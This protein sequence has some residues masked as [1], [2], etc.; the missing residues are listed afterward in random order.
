M[1]RICFLQLALLALVSGTAHRPQASVL[2]AMSLA[3]LAGAAESIV[4][5]SVRSVR[6]AWDDRHRTIL[7]TIEVD[8]NEV[9]KGS[10]SSSQVV[11]VTTGG[12]VGDIEMSGQGMPTFAVGEKSLL[13]LRGTPR[14]QVV[15][16]SQGKR[17]L[18]WDGATSQWLAQAPSRDG[19]VELGPGAKLR[20][21]QRQPVVPLT[22]LRE[23][24][25]RALGAAP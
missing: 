15:G 19:V 3:E 2:R 4:V 23:Q 18:V 20:Q 1:R 13:F 9:W 12:S 5:G 24:V 16:M 8:V 6:C 14:L 22:E 7:S 11:L 17:T 10:V 25:K 21:A